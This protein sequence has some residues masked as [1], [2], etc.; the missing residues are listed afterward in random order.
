MCYIDCHCC[1]AV[2]ICYMRSY[3]VNSGFYGLLGYVMPLNDLSAAVIFFSVDIF[4][5]TGRYP[6]SP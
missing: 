5:M 3:R 2:K 1:Y 4:L 6:R